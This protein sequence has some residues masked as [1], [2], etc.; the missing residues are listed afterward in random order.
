DVEDVVLV[1]ESRQL[2]GDAGHHGPGDDADSFAHQVGGL[3]DGR[4][5]VATVVG[6]DELDRPAVDGSASVSGVGAS[7]L[8]SGQILLAVTLEWAGGGGDDPNLDRISA[9]LGGLGGVGGRLG[10]IGRRFGGGGRLIR[11]CRGGCRGLGG[12]AGTGGQHQRHH[13]QQGDSHS[14]HL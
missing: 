13:Q 6:D 9:G 5:G 4:L 7:G 8:E 1:G 2:N 10:G 12:V 11:C 3:A 14:L